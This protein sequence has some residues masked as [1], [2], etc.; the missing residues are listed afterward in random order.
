[1]FLNVPILY[2]C[3]I[4]IQPCTFVQCHVIW[5]SFG[6]PNSHNHRSTAVSKEQCSTVTVTDLPGDVKVQKQVYWTL[7]IQKEQWHRKLIGDLLQQLITVDHFIVFLKG[8][9]REICHSCQVLRAFHL[10]WR[11]GNLKCAEGKDK[12]SRISKG[13]YCFITM[14]C[15]FIQGI[16]TNVKWQAMKYSLSC[17]LDLPPLLTDA[18]P[19]LS[20]NHGNLGVLCSLVQHC[21]Q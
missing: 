13:H 12:V 9:R 3:S 7:A 5:T 14:S 21:D 2:A 20:G 15:F 1:M 6:Q 16:T 8:L 17:W 10:P 18:A 19:E 4:H 11:G